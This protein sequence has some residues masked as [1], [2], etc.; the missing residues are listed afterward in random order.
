MSRRAA[1]HQFVPV[2]ARHDAIGR[3]T[4]QLRR[5]LQD[6]GLDSELFVADAHPDLDV[7]T[8]DPASFRPEPGVPTWLLYQASTDSDMADDLVARPEPLI[9]DYHNITP[10]EMFAPWEPLVA[11][12]LR[13]AR[14]QLARLSPRSVL[15]LADSSYNAVELD[16]LGCPRT[17]VAPILFDVSGFDV[18]P[19]RGVVERLAVG[20]GVRW[21]FVGR[22]A[23][24]KAQHDVVRAFALYRRVFDPDAR[25]CLVGGSS[26]DRYWRAVEG[27]VAEL[28]LVDAVELA[29]SVSGEALA[30]YYESAD[31]FVCLS[32]HEGFCV[33]L[34]EA[35]HHGVPVVAFGSSAV[36]ETLGAGGVC[37]PE[38]SPVLVAAAVDRVVSDP[39]VRDAL[40]AAGRRRLED[41]DLSRT[42]ATFTTAIEALLADAGV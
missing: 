16:S 12:G 42:R 40:V 15:G 36:P 3:H 9:L 39:Q 29:G 26:S 30:A 37:L 1:I 20:G 11:P 32:D 10:A 22:V 31:V 17:V 6:M 14:R 23:P 8:H 13:M 38:K 34:L 5:L 27:L 19:D 25:L 4:V 7:P 24:N 18:V 2:L 21:L 41:F 28:D 35:M 33:P